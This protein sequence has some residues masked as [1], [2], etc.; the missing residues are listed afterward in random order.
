MNGRE[1]SHE[2]PR[3]AIVGSGFLAATRMR[4]YHNL[5]APGADVVTVCSRDPERARAFA[6]EHGI[7]SSEEDFEAVLARQ[8]VD[9]VDLP[10]AIS[11]VT[12]V[13]ARGDEA[14]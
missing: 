5:R 10:A 14:R 7:R 2:L 12:V 11:S 3:I 13:K 6:T 9:A 1:L 8:D 4:C